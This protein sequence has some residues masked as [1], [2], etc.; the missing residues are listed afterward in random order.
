MWAGKE[1]DREAEKERTQPTEGKEEVEEG[2]KGEGRE[3]RTG[4]V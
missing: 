3:R 4:R 1:R 2:M